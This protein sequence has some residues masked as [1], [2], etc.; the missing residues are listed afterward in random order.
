MLVLLERA[1]G[2]HLTFNS[3]APA[4]ECKLDSKLCRAARGA[5]AQT[6]RRLPSV[7]P[8]SKLVR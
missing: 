5:V 3:I 7:C 1:G 8:S 4:P 2:D 6:T